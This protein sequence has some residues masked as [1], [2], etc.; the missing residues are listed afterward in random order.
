MQFTGINDKNDKE[1][2]EGDILQQWLVDEIEDDGGFYWKVEVKF[3]YGAW[4][5]CELGFDKY[6]RENQPEKLYHESFDSNPFEI[7]GNIYANPELI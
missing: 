5:V 4:C 3:E 2:Y 7:I 6:S 1:I